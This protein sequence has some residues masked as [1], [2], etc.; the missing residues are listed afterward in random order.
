MDRYPLALIWC[1]LA[2]LVAGGAVPGEEKRAAFDGPDELKEWQTSGDVGFEALRSHGADG[3]SLRIGP[4]GKAVWL[5]RDANGSGTV[6][7]WVYDD[8]SAPAKPK[9][10]VTGP[11]YGV[12]QSDGR[13]LAPG[14]LY[15]PYLS[16][17]KA[18]AVTAFNPAQKEQAYF[19]VQY[20]GIKRTP[21][22]HR[23]TFVFDSEEGVSLLHNDKNVNGRRERF[24]WYTTKVEG[25]TGVV[26]VGDM[27]ADANQTIW[28]DD[29]TVTL[30]GGMTVTPTQLA[31]PP[32]PPATP[33]TDPVPQERVEI[34]PELRNV[35][36]RLLFTA[37]DI[38]AMKT[39]LEAGYGKE[40]FAKLLA[41]L[42]ACRKPDHTKFLKDATDGQRQG[43][44]RLP[45]VALH[46]VLTGEKTS[47][48]RTVE[49][50]AFLLGLENWETGELDSGMS[51][52]N[53][54]VGAA[55]AYD[56]LYND[57]KPAFRDKYRD[58][59]L[60]M[61]RRQY[62]Q[63][64]L[65]KLKGTHYW[66]GDPAN[67]HRFHRDAGMTLAIL[68]AAEEEKTDDDWLL[69]ETLKEVE[70]VVKWLPEDGSCHESPTYAVFGNTHLML[71]VDAAQRCFGKP[72][73]NHP[74]FKTTATF[75]LQT[76]RPDL[77][78]IFAYGDSGG[79]TSGY[80]S[81]LH[82]AC[83]F[84]ELADDQAG[85]SEATR[86]NE[87]FIDFSWFSIIWWQAL[88]RGAIANLP[89]HAFFPDLG[90]AT[91]RTGWE[92][93]DVGA[94]F[95]C[96]PFGGY[97][98]N[99][100]RHRNKMKYVNVAHDDPDANSFILFADGQMLAETDRYSKRKKSANHN[101]ILI[102][103]AG[104]VAAGRPEGKGWSQPGGNM[105]EMAVVTSYARKG[106][107]VAL[108]GE[109]AG[110]YLADPRGGPKR[111]ALDRFR[112]VFI[113]LEGGYILV[114]DDIRAPT[115]VEVSWLM[116]GPQLEVADE[117]EQRFTLR[118]DDASC[119][120]QVVASETLK[121]AIAISSADHRGNAL[122]WQ[123]LRLSADAAAIRF[124]SVY[125]P[126]KRGKLTVALS[127]DGPNKATVTVTG[128][129]V[130]HTWEWQ[131]AQ[132]GFEPSTVVGRDATGAELLTMDR[133][134]PRTQALLAEIPGRR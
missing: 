81:Y 43:F 100:Y 126:W 113:W 75:K 54:M 108:E 49:F 7:L 59:L 35:H 65:M 23:W 45:T 88:P 26:L 30:G 61:A 78:G 105:A 111:P 90:L 16:G 71:V 55:L 74:F 60:L 40:L 98:L 8:G 33:D 6:D 127:P 14:S 130:E 52:A 125:D 76:M 104:Q 94:M 25:F 21:G 66:Q 63:G 24:K 82:R 72:F 131:A 101:T 42:P 132:E 99:E 20:L 67:N 10:R 73:L 15:A 128:P 28:V 4:G 134:E 107:N 32:P 51:S 11:Y 47:F 96:G 115:P 70:F 39:K 1:V 83:A 12:V 86:R 114:L 121:S 29:V 50:M 117:G 112:R 120:F 102:N 22:W 84:H 38:P 103:G 57:L 56:W 118:K 92:G 129:G 34:V 64:H 5:L 87:K 97:E 31:P 116:Q 106:K 53:I 119:A 9:V 48:D 95:K 17:D 69:A 3:G 89:R 58:K 110:S 91:F 37:A 123:Q 18:Y 80:H 133:S 122:G 19:A 124:V 2:A 41:Y 46:Y 77:K 44:W 79:G 27:T 93:A 36:P 68:A 62:H 85:V 109:A 13:V